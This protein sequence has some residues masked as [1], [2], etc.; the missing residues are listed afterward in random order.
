MNIFTKF[1]NNFRSGIKSLSR[2]KEM[3]SFTAVFSNF[4]RNM[5]K[6]EIV[7]S[8]IRPLAEQTSKASATCTDKAIERLLKL[9]P[10]PFMNGKDFLYKVRTQYELKNTA[11]IL[12]MRENNV[13]TG[14]Y[15]IP[16][17]TFEGLEDEQGDI[18]I[19]FYTAKGEYIFLWDDLVVLRK[20]YNEHDIGGD[21]NDILLNTLEMINVSNQSI[22]NAIKSTANLRGILKSTKS[23]LDVNDTKNIRD[24]F[25]KNYMDSANEG[26]VAVLD[27]S[28]EFTPIN[29]SPTIATWN[30]QKEFRENVYRYFGVSDEIIMSKA[31]PEQM[32]VFYEMKIEPFLMALSQELTRKLFSERQ[33]AFGNE[34]IFQSST[35]QFMSMSDKLALK[36]YID[37][38]ALTPNTWCDIVGLPHVEG[39]DEPIR[40]LD[41]APVSKVASSLEGEKD[42]E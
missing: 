1:I 33:L 34:V 11:F 28:M 24:E 25:I 42:D 29:M 5:N 36:D 23:M 17:I 35:I 40:R 6:S 21:D 26:G 13:I 30:N 4:G 12:I 15:P 8:C 22:S 2:W 3:G 10:N 19:K 31:T 14:F 18:Y 37:R 32:Q 27:A 39:G 41:T 9:S 38:G 20:D 16:Y 7:R